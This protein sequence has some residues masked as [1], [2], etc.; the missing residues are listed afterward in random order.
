MFDCH[1]RLLSIKTVNICSLFSMLSSWILMVS[2]PCQYFNDTL[3]GSPSAGMFNT[4]WIMKN[5]KSAS[6]FGYWL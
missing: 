4:I 2:L 5:F 1:I 6:V 3:T